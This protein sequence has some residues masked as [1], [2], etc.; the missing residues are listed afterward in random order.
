MERF[1]KSTSQSTGAQGARVAW[2]IFLSLP[3]GVALLWLIALVMGAEPTATGG[4]GGM[5]GDVAFWIWL[6]VAL[7]GL[8]GAVFFRGRAVA[9]AEE[10]ARRGDPGSQAGAVQ[11]W[12][13]IG[14]AL[15][16]AGAL[17]AGVFVYLGADA[18][19]LLYAAPIYAIGLVLT[20]PRA[21]WL[22]T[23]ER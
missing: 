16:E 20:Y 3:M 13:I 5:D 12:L 19:L 9:V 10:T 8:A 14:W 22:G 21:E 18:R 6:V 23:G 15:L 1:S 4:P 11:S 17:L 7:G 2:M